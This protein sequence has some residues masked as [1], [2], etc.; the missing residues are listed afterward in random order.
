MMLRPHDVELLRAGHGFDA[1]VSDTRG[2]GAQRRLEVR[3][4]ATGA[5]GEVDPPRAVA[6]PVEVALRPMRASVFPR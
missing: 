6:L 3:L 4:R 5:T 1:T 2:F